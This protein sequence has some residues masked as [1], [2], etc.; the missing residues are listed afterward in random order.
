VSKIENVAFN[1]VRVTWNPCNSPASVKLAV[2]C[3]STDF[4]S[5]RGVKGLPFFIQIDT[6]ENDVLRDR[7]SAQIKTFCDK[8]ADRKFKD[9]ERRLIQGPTL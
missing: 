4:T 1:G 5:Q 8:G 9:E 3:L 6:F 7:A 2:R